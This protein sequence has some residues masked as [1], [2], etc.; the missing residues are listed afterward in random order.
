MKAR[1]ILYI[2][3]VKIKMAFILKAAARVEMRVAASPGGSEPA[4]RDSPVDQRSNF[5][6]REKLLDVCRSAHLRPLGRLRPHVGERLGPSAPRLEQFWEKKE[7]FAYVAR[8]A[9]LQDHRLF[10]QRPA[11]ADR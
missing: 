8:P 3:N 7:K 4:A 9:Q 10:H 6:Q 2:H 1:L 5:A 11:V